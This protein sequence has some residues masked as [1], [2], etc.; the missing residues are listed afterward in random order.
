MAEF[1]HLDREG[2]ALMV[3]I[4][5]KEKTHRTAI[6]CGFIHM[7][8]EVVSQIASGSNKKGDIL[9]AARIAGIM[10]AKRTW[11]LIPLCHQIML[12]KV[13]IDFS[14]DSEKSGLKCVCTAVSEGQTGVEMEALTGVSTALLTVYDMCKSADRSMTIGDIRLVRKSGGKSGTYI[15]EEI[16]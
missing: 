4:S 11:E 12:T 13:T 2:N 16:E 6:A 8:D 15:G 1:T 10:A 3:D 14:L 5:D 9:A 7:N